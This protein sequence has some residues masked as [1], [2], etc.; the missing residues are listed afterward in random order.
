MAPDVNKTLQRI[1]DIVTLKNNRLL[2]GALPFITCMGLGYY[3]L[4]F[5]TDVM[6]KRRSARK[7][8]MSFEEAEKKFGLN[9][10]P[11]EERNKPGTAQFS[12][13][14]WKLKTL[15]ACEMIVPIESMLS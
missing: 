10:R 11:K 3:G 5:M 13:E 4:T 2:R 12:L 14:R 8:I 6:V 7:G 1:K 15:V 9:L